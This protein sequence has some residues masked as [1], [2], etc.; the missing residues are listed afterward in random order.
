MT[1]L[2][3]VRNLLAV[4]CIFA[5]ANFS[6]AQSDPPN[7]KTNNSYPNATE[8]GS[9]IEGHSNLRVP[10]IRQVHLRNGLILVIYADG[11]EEIVYEGY[12]EWMAPSKGKSSSSTH[13]PLET[14]SRYLKD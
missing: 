1:T 6:V 8:K 9:G 2:T 14:N 4:L 3:T 12:V 7:G 10:I 13:F 11:S 5:F